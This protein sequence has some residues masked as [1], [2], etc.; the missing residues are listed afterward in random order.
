MYEEKE[1]NEDEGK[2]EV[3]ITGDDLP[4]FPSRFGG[5]IGDYDLSYPVFKFDNKASIRDIIMKAIE[6]NWCHIWDDGDQF[7]DAKLISYD[8]SDNIPFG[9]HS[10]NNIRFSFL[11]LEAEAG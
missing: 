7:K 4:K 3:L 2:L 6:L 5:E 9:D 8:I 11:R 1:D 10:K